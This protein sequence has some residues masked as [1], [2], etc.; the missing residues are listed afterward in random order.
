[1]ARGKISESLAK[2]AFNVVKGKKGKCGWLW[3]KAKWGTL[4]FV[5]EA[6]N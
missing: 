4:T 6:E 2:L 1:V 5:V 3:L